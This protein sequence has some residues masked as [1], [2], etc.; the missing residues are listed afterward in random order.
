MEIPSVF[1]M[2]EPYLHCMYV[3]MY[4]CMC[5]YI[6]IYRDIYIYIYMCVCV[7]AYVC[8]YIYMSDGCRNGACS[9]FGTH[10]FFGLKGVLVFQGWRRAPATSP[11]ERQAYGRMKEHS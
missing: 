7:C 8:V 9:A 6:Y 3:C 10:R 1:T 2:F 5:V 4:V 11:E